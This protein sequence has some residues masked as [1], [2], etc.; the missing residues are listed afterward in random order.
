MNKEMYN[1][2]LLLLCWLEQ[3]E[4]DGADP[5]MQDVWCWCAAGSA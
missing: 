1:F 2:M 4:L 3:R 5:R